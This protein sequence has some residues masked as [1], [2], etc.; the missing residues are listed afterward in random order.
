MKLSSKLALFC[1][2]LS[3][4]A[5]A[6]DYSPP[7][8]NVDVFRT[9]LTTLSIQNLSNE[10]VEID[11]YGEIFN[12]IPDSGVKFDCSGYENIE[13]QIKNNDHSYFE[14]PCQSRV[15]ISELFKN[16]YRQGE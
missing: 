1:S 5:I 6:N 7:I 8:N 16:Q 15:I 9:E 10:Q 12:L 2:L 13:L 11:L 14:I 4:A 3:S